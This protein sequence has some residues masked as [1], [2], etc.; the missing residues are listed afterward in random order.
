MRYEKSVIDL[1]TAAYCDPM[2]AQ[3]KELPFLSV[4]EQ[5]TYGLDVL[6][7]VQPMYWVLSAL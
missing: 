2:P 4:A 3:T 1:A 6:E 5:R 7:K